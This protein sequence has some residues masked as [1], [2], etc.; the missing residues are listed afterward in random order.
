MFDNIFNSAREISEE[1]KKA[2]TSGDV[3]KIGRLMDENQELL[4]KI[5]VSCDELER[6]IKIAKENG[7]VGAKLTGT[8]RGGLM[9]ALTPGKEIQDKVARAMEENGFMVLRANVG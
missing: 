4:R 1:A 7:A 6:L 2:L 3:E 5:G 8:G 9:V